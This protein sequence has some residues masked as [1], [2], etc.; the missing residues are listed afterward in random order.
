MPCA[1]SDP[2]PSNLPWSCIV[3]YL[4]AWNMAIPLFLPESHRASWSL[5]PQPIVIICW[6][7]SVANRP[8]PFNFPNHIPRETCIILLPED[9]TELHKDK[10][11][12]QGLSL[13]QRTRGGHRFY[14]AV[15]V[16]PC[17]LNRVSCTTDWH[18]ARL[19][20]VCP[21]P[22]GQLSHSKLNTG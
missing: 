4:A 8:L 22:S 5:A 12:N 18:F 13:I 16:S 10:N 11:Q 6:A 3:G 9:H 21:Y 14:Q 19:A 20:E 15:L 7:I 1:Y 17:P 2:F